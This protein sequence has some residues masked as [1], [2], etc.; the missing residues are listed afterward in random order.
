MQKRQRA[1]DPFRS[2]LRGR[3]RTM[4]QHLT[5]AETRLWSCIRNDQLDG[6]RFRRQRVIGP[7][8]ADFTCPA[9]MLIVEVDG[10]SHTDPE[11]MR[12]D[13][14]RSEYFVRHGLHVLRFT[15]VEVL[16]NIDGVV[17]EVRRWAR[18]Q[19]DCPSP[20]PSPQRTGAREDLSQGPALVACPGPLGDA[21]WP[22]RQEVPCLPRRTRDNGG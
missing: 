12:R 6:L 16:T 14:E 7:Y 4:R 13:D 1:S 3:A 2:V 11:Q 22:D 21:D 8:V 15:N 17:A 5:P 10:D 20:P 18:E 19:R 9:L